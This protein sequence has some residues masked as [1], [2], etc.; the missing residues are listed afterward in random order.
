MKSFFISDFLLLHSLKSSIFDLVNDDLSSLLSGSLLSRFSLLFFLE[1][2]E[3]LD[4][5]HE[6]EF[7]LLFDPLLLKSFILLQLLVSDG[8]DLG[9]EDHLVH[10]FDIVEVLIKLLL[11]LGKESLC[12]LSLIDLPVGRLNFGGSLGIHFE[13]FGLSCLRLCHSGLFLFLKKLLFLDS[14]LLG[15]DGGSLSNS[16]HIGLRDDNGIC[17]I[18]FLSVLSNPS[19]LV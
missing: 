6:V 9:V 18:V 5:H 7:L 3:S 12:L 10:V 14:L 2:L 15:F 1:D 17:L 19:E 11:S 16:V 13:H 8:H 4:F